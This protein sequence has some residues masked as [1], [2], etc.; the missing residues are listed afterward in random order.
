MENSKM[1]QKELDREIAKK[2]NLLE[3]LENRTT[4]CTMAMMAY[5]PSIG[6][7]FPKGGVNRFILMAWEMHRYLASIADQREFDVWHDKFVQTLIKEIG[8]TSKGKPISYGQAQKPINVFLKLYVDWA[9]LPNLKIA[10]R[11]RPCLHVPLD[12][13]V[14]KYS[15]NNFPKYYAEFKL[16]RSSLATI[17]KVQY[18]RW[19]DFFRKVN[20]KK[21]LLLDVFWAV[22]RFKSELE[23][24]IS[25]KFKAS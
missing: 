12:S 4:F 25:H 9:D 22:G 19:Q 20:P 17:D 15:R 10:N 24:I 6:R 2:I 16:K 11:L 5:N 14:M 18:Y 13:R 23:A 3:R 8:E 7:V 1:K 21:P